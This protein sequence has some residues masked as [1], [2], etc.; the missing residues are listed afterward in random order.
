[1]PVRNEICRVYRDDSVLV[2]L[3]YDAR[4][5]LARTQVDMA[6]FKSLPIPFMHAAIDW[7]R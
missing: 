3:R 6:P 1:V 7:A 5:R 4:N 2:Q